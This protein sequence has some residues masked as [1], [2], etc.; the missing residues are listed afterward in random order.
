[1]ESFFDFLLTNAR[2]RKRPTEATAAG[3]VVEKKQK[4]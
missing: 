3:A 4:T 1:V 2:A